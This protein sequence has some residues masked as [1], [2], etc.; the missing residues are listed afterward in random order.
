MTPWKGI[1]WFSKLDARGFLGFFRGHSI[2]TMTFDELIS[3]LRRGMSLVR[4][5]D[6]ETANLRGKDTWHQQADGQLSKMLDQLLLGIYRSEK[7]VLGVPVSVV[8]NSFLTLVIHQVRLLK[9]IWSTR[10]LL[11]CK[12]MRKLNPS[13]LVDSHIFLQQPERVSELLSNLDLG[14]RDAIYVSSVPS[15]LMASFS[16]R[17]SHLII[18]PRNAYS[19]VE[20]VRQKLANWLKSA[21][22]PIIFFSAGSAVK[23]LVLE[24]VHRCQIIDLGSGLRFLDTGA[25]KYEWDL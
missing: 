6:G 3:A 19:Q 17:L 24:L 11:N 5:G 25:Q 9:I 16:L 1:Q 23:V 14:N 2:Q 20:M 22:K 12:L 8:E 10:V 7:L 21:E 18:P 15:N 4:W 13:R